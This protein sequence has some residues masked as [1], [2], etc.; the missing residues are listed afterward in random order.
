MSSVAKAASCVTCG[1]ILSGYRRDETLGF[2]V[3]FCPRCEPHIGAAPIVEVLP[4]PAFP[5]EAPFL[6]VAYPEVA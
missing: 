6:E 2:P 1:E 4:E 3:Y 5:E